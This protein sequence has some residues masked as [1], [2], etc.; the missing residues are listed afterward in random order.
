MKLNTSPSGA[1][2]RRAAAARDRTARGRTSPSR[3]GGRRSWPARA[4]TGVSCVCRGPCRVR[5]AVSDLTREA[6]VHGL[7]S[8][9]RDLAANILRMRFI[10]RP[11]GAWRSARSGLV[12]Q[13]GACRSLRIPAAR[14]SEEAGDYTKALLGLLGD[15]DP[16]QVLRETPS[17]DP[18]D[19]R[20]RA[21]QSGDDSR[22]RRGNG[23]SRWWP[24]TWRTAIWSGAGGCG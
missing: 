15:R 24:S 7:G 2:R 18:G 19:S 14:S 8:P 9:G 21:G 1:P 5:G 10:A 16:M 4:E 6:R 12:V 13:N 22:R 17:G 23:R 3:R 20:R 11:A